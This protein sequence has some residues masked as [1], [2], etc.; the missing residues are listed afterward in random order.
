MGCRYLTLIHP[1]NCERRLGNLLGRDCWMLSFITLWKI[2]SNIEMNWIVIILWIHRIWLEE[3]TMKDVI[4]ATCLKIQHLHLKSLQMADVGIFYICHFHFTS[5]TL[6]KFC[7]HAVFVPIFRCQPKWLMWNFPT[8]D[9]HILCLTKLTC[10]C[11]FGKT[12]LLSNDCPF[13]LM[14]PCATEASG[15]KANQIPGSPK[16]CSFCLS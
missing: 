15:L 10:R 14:P 5:A 13:Q 8:S 16:G 12:A 7:K 3:A 1:G 11:L 4:A 6:I 9:I 2:L